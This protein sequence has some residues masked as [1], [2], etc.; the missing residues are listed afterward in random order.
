ME[1]EPLIK[2]L[3]KKHNNKQD[4]KNIF[5]IF[6]LLFVIAVVLFSIYK[7]LTNT[8]NEL[9]QKVEIMGS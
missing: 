1:K 9:E 7:K 3:E 5:T 2:T 4:Y 8:I 6:S